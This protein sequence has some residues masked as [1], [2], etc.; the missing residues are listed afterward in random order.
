MNVPA[1]AESEET[2]PRERNGM[3]LEMKTTEERNSPTMRRP[4]RCSYNLP[5]G[6]ET[7]SWTAERQALGA[8]GG[9]QTITGTL[10]RGEGGQGSEEELTPGS[11]CL[12]GSKTRCREMS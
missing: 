5:R 3:K 10:V 6:S 8:Q 4:W 2:H 12:H 9:C 11:S 1:L 7:L